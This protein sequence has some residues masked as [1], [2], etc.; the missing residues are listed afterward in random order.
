MIRNLKALGLALV[1]VFAIGAIGA[2]AASAV[3]DHFTAG[4]KAT[5]LLTGTGTNHKYEITSGPSI[6]CTTSKFT[7][8]GLNNSTEV[9]IDATY[10]GKINETPHGTPCTSPLGNV[11][12]ETNSCAYILSGKTTGSDEGLTDATFSVECTTLG[13]HIVLTAPLGCKIKVP[14]Q[15]PTSGGVTYTNLPNHTG[16]SAIE[17]KITAT[18][19]TYTSE[20]CIGVASEGNDSDYTGSVILTGYEDLD[21]LPTPITEGNQIGVSMT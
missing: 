4:G 12:I 5:A 7:G 6:Q 21:G 10:T 17:V 2:S 16:G 13:D 11:T 14:V 15:T 3:E 20:N 18:G 19:V 8:T 1:A 9:T